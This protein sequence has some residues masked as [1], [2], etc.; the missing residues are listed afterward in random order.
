MTIYYSKLLK[1][2]IVVVPRRVGRERARALIACRKTRG[3]A[4]EVGLKRLAYMKQ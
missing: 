3:E 1:G 4:L 2:Y